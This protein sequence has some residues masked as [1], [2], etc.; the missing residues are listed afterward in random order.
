MGYN[1]VKHLPFIHPTGMRLL[2]DFRFSPSH[3]QR[4]MGPKWGCILAEQDHAITHFVSVPKNPSPPC[5]P[6]KLCHKVENLEEIIFYGLLSAC[7]MKRELI[8]NR[9]TRIRTCIRRCCQQLR[10]STASSSHLLLLLLIL[11]L[12]IINT[13]LPVSP[14]HARLTGRYLILHLT[15]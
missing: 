13:S 2:I 1:W 9:Y 5:M 7:Y 3:V 4:F 6:N 15:L 12:H 14:C 11:C 8:E 10:R